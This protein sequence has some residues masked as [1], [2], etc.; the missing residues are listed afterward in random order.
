MRQLVEQLQQLEDKLREGGGKKKIEKQHRE[1]KLTARERI[2]KL[3]DPGRC[4]WK[5]GCWLH[6]TFMKVR[7]R[8]RGLLPVSGV[9]KTGRRLLSQMTQR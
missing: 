6:M 8:R 7:L 2:A 3:I 4:F 9:L 5:S 1:G